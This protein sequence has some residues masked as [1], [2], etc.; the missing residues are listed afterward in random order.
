MSVVEKV[1]KEVGTRTRMARSCKRMTWM[2][3]RL[4]GNKKVQD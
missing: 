1:F 2:G 4:R 3:E